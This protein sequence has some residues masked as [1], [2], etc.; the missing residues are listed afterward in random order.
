MKNL[1]S[2]ESRMFASLANPKRLEILHILQHKSVTVNELVEMTNIPQAN[3]SQHLSVLRRMG[4][5]TS[6]K[7]AQTRHYEVASKH[8][9]KIMNA[10]R[11][12]LLEH[13]GVKEIQKLE[14]LHLHTDPVCG[15]EIA[16]HQ[17][18][19]SVVFNHKRYYFCGLGCEKKFSESPSSYIQTSEMNETK[20]TLP[21]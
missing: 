20:D 1:T 8:I 15:M 2:L 11:L 21:V 10:M 6:Q 3:V 9:P 16:A 13:Y 7:L 17:A 12:L 18:E 14:A 5:V 4:L 19:A